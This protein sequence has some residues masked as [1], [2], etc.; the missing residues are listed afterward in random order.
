VTPAGGLAFNSSDALLSAAV[1]GAG[2]VHV[3]DLLA[4]PHLREG[5]LL[6]VL[7]DW[8]TEEQV[9]YVVYPRARFTAPKI[10]AFADFAAQAFPGAARPDSSP[11]HVRDRRED[12][13]TRTTRHTN[14]LERGAQGAGPA[15]I[16]GPDF[17][18]AA[19]PPSSPVTR[20]ARSPAV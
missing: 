20:A 4:D 9:F 8:A 10:R 13:P 6:P 16:A 5:R 7:Q 3:L 11:G 15:A 17:R 18:P 14:R 19:P 1:Q 2:L 12:R